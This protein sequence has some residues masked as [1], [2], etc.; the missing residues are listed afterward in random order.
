[1]TDTLPRRWAVAWGADDVRPALLAPDGAV[2]TSGGLAER[3]ADAARRLAAAGIGPGSRVLLSAAPSVDLVVAYVA[4]MRLGAVVVP[5]NTAYTE[6]ELAHLLADARP[7]A[8]VLDD[9]SRL[10]GRDDVR[11]L[12]TDLSLPP[13]PPVPLDAARPEDPAWI[14]YTSGTTGRPKGAVLT[15]ANLAAG[16]G[17]LVDAWEWTPDDRLVLALPLFH[18]HGLGVGLNG[19]LAAGA[20]AVVLPRF[21]PSAVAA[22]AEG[23]GGTMFFAVPTMYERLLAT[24]HASAL[25]GLRLLVSGSAPLPPPLFEGVRAAAGQAPLER[26]GMT[27]TVMLCANPLHGQRRSGTVGHP[28]PGVELRLADD[29]G[30]Q[31]RGPSVFAGY[32]GRPEA[33]AEAF[34]ED[35][36]FRTGD[37]GAWDEAGY[38]RLVGRTSDLVI[39]GGFNVYPREVEDALRAHPAVA[40]VAVVGLPDQR[41]GEVVAAFVVRAVSPGEAVAKPSDLEAFLTDRLASYKRPRA[42]RFVAELPRNAMGKVD[43]AAL[44]RS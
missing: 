7:L 25:A 13:G 31:V 32:L 22:A 27:E 9:P 15:H 16:A 18:M 33:T 3:S 14:A 36:F 29:G 24:G 12:T 23:R 17:V 1:M 37:V 41:R 2:L 34:T 44:R 38:L 6:P 19:T 5:A 39:T 43:R 35:G 8:A 10:A 11:V 26:Y 30:V 21:D 20:S 40:D 28:L 42:W 4:L